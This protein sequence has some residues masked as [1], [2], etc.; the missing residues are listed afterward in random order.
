MIVLCCMMV[1]PASLWGRLATHLLASCH[2]IPIEQGHLEAHLEWELFPFTIPAGCLWAEV[3]L[4]CMQW[5][6]GHHS[7]RGYWSIL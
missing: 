6:H 1:L 4:L 3:R 5:I 2:Q 7:D